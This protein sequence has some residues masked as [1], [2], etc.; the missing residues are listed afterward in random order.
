MREHA[1]LAESNAEIRR[2]AR[3][4]CGAAGGPRIL[5]ARPAAARNADS[6]ADSVVPVRCKSVKTSHPLM[7]EIGQSRRYCA[8]PLAYRDLVIWPS[9]RSEPADSPDQVFPAGGEALG[10]T[11]AGLSKGVG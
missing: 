11:E 1:H 3:G 5:A 4:L 2:C 6:R 8:M 7:G 10:D 9:R